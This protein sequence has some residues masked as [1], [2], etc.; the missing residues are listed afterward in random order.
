MW[1]FLSKLLEH[2]GVVITMSA[3]AFVAFAA[4]VR[5]LWLH[6]Q[7][8]HRQIREDAEAHNK[9]LNELQEKRLKHAQEMAKSVTELAHSVK[10]SQDNL[11]HSIEMLLKIGGGN[12]RP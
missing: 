3:L 2:G 8:L 6:N 11:A 12:G 7:A 1:S 5:A 4:T 9:Q 10:T